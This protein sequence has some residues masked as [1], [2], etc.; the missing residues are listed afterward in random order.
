[1]AK[2]KTFAPPPLSMEE[3]M[4][5]LAVNI[6]RER[7]DIKAQTELLKD[8]EARLLAYMVSENKPEFKGFQ[9][10]SRV[11]TLKFDGATGKN[12]ATI[13]AKLI[14]ELGANY[15]TTELD[16]DVMWRNKDTDTAL[17][18]ALAFH[19]ITLVQNDSTNSLKA[20]KE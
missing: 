20:V 17:R 12:L 3:Q 10:V 2:L 9:M 1:M 6:A 7:A 8:Q 11:G 14:A 4:A 16:I 15:T 19:K 5:E 18:N 13:K